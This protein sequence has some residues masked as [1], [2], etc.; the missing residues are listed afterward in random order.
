MSCSPPCFKLIK[1]IDEHSNKKKTNRQPLLIKPPRWCI[2]QIFGLELSFSP[3]SS[4]RFCFDCNYSCVC[5]MV[6]PPKTRRPNGSSHFVSLCTIHLFSKRSAP[7]ACKAVGATNFH[8]WRWNPGDN[9]CDMPNNRT[10]W[11]EFNTLD[12]GIANAPVA[13]NQCPL[14]WSGSNWAV[15]GGLQT[16]HTRTHTHTLDDVCDLL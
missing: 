6:K 1:H 3:Y 5:L 8:S 2:D 16:S 12:S 4:A 15:Q 13:E 14:R 11:F 7:C 10:R 9:R